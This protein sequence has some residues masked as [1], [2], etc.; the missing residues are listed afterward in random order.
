[1]IKPQQHESNS[2]CKQL[3]GRGDSSDELPDKVQAAH[4]IRHHIKAC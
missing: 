1:M 2:E 4:A 3:L